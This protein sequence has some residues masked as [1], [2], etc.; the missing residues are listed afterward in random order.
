MYQDLEQLKQRLPL[1]DYLL[2]SHWMA[3]RA[4]ASAEFVGLCPL[5]RETQPSFYVNARKNLFYCHGC[6]QGGDLIR[7][8]ELAEHLPFRQSL[9]FLQRQIAAPDDGAVIERTAAFYQLQLHRHPEAIHYLQQRGLRDAA[10]IEELG[11]G[12]APGGNLRRHLAAQGCA[13]DRL[14]DTGLI[15]HQGRDT[16]CRRV[17]FPCRQH[18]HIVNLYGRSIG[19]AFPHRL[20]PRSKGGLFAW[21]SVRRFHTVILVE[22]LFDLAVLWQAGFRNTTCALGTHLTPC[23]FQQLTDRPD[24]SIYILFD[25]DENHAGQQAAHQLARRLADAGVSARMVALP[26]GHDPNS[27]LV[28]GATAADFTRCLHRAQPL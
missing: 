13:L 8:V 7:F 9:A 12:Y 3:R 6:G 19:A 25:Q 4:G 20:L 28:A 27:Y 14:L 24:R 21:E 26:S 23:Q 1:L 2:R 18:G 10:L 22:G 16:F 11:I 15:N 17:I 5:H